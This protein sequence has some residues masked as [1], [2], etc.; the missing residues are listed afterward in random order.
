ALVFSYC[1]TGSPHDQYFFKRPEHM[2]A[3]SVTPPRLDLTNE[4]LV[5]AHIYAIWLAETGLS[6]GRSLKDI[7]EVSG[8]EPTLALLGSVQDSIE[9][10]GARYRAQIRAIRVLETL[11][12]ELDKA[13]WYHGTGWLEKELDQVVTH[14]DQ[15]CE[16]WRSLYR[17][18]QSQA[19]V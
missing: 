12:E 6:L 18:A 1:S 15:T 9:D 19:K 2:V 4:D 16:R 3:G 10:L 14:F 11:Q 7:L 5:R 13:D 8:D 17:A